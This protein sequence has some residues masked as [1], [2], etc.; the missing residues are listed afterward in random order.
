MPVVLLVSLSLMLAIAVG[1]LAAYVWSRRYDRRSRPLTLLMDALAALPDGMVVLDNDQRVAEINA[2]ASQLLG[3]THRAARGQALT[4]LLGTTPHGA[5]LRPLLDHLSEPGTR[6]LS[7]GDAAGEQ[8]L[9]V[10][11]RP[12]RATNGA[13]AGTLLLLRDVSERIHAEQSRAQHLAELSLI[14]RVAR[15]ANTAV[16]AEGLVRAAA[17]SIAAAGIWDRVTVG[18]LAP[19]GAGLRIVADITTEGQCAGYEGQVIGGAEGEALSALLRAG[20]SQTLAMRDPTTAASALGQALA[21][22]GISQL[23]LVPLYHQGAPLGMLALGTSTRGHNSPALPRV[24]E[25]IGE[26]ITDA[27]V[28]ARLYDELH[29][30]DQ[31]KSSFLASVSH[32]LRTPLTAIIGYVELLRR[33]GYGPLDERLQEPLS[34][35]HLSSATLLRMINDILDYTRAEAGH[36]RFDLQPVD[37]R[38]VVANVVGQLQPLIQERGLAFELE[39]APGL[40]YV[41]SNK[42][43]LEQIVTNLLSN[44]VKF[45][46]QGQ[47]AVRAWQVGDR[48]RLSV[49]DTGI[50]IAPE[51]QELIFQEFRRVEAPSRRA[52]GTGLG[53]AISRRLAALMGGSISVES[54]P[55]Q[56]STFTVELAVFQD[57]DQDAS[58]V[59]R[60]NADE[61]PVP[62]PAAREVAA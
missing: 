31:L 3:T 5:A 29:Q 53:L 46:E 60:R 34:Y 17:E 36:L 20:E 51:H 25:T 54:A 61:R 57:L 23:L 21:R 39:I 22:E 33:G 19:D 44:A 43:R 12:L 58:L 1:L 41:Q 28:R 47:V 62:S 42:V 52:G 24:A 13:V 35:M 9:E 40:P 16:D 38:H 59:A 14:N 10:R 37:V 45:T 49:S 55:G 8:T 26:L 56:G 48:V 2:A 18:L 4:S 6:L 11:I 50:G 32:E 7:Y 30:A 27:V 15:A